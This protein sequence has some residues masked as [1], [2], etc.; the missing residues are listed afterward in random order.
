MSKLVWAEPQ[1][2]C[3]KLSSDCM[4]TAWG[5]F[6]PVSLPYFK[7]GRWELFWDYVWVY[8]MLTGLVFSLVSNLI[9]IEVG[10]WYL[11]GFVNKPSN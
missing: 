1:T 9:L 4:K 8:L 5:F 3:L 7:L 10:L 11:F 6:A 2:T